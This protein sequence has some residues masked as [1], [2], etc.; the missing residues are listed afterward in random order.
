MD[1]AYSICDEKK[2]QKKNPSA[3][4]IEVHVYTAW[5]FC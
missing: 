4:E 5:F 1:Y 3:S 2:N